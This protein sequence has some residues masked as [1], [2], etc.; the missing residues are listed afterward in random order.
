MSKRNKIKWRD[1][2]LRELERIVRNYNAKLN[3]V[4]E[5]NPYIED[6]LPQKASIRELKKRIETRADFNR[7]LNSLARFSRKG[8]EEIVYTEKGLPLTKYEVNETKLKTRIVNQKRSNERKRLGISEARGTMGQAE[9]QNLRPKNFN[10]NKNGKE[11]EKFVESLDKEIRGNFKG[12]LLEGY[13]N[14]YI[15][16]LRR[17][18]GEGGEKL[19]KMLE[20]VD[21]ETLYNNSVSNPL[22]SLDFIYD[23]LEFETII[24]AKMEA[25]G[26]VI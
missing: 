25:W 15:S 2:D 24:S 14:N 13:K 3:R 17:N 7:E 21:P 23:P 22:L 5:K 12:E 1:K 6:I 26:E 19:A 10:L 18:L 11:W 16:A 4:A 20:G 8:S 9:N